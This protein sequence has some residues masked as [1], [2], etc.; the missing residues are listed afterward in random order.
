MDKIR[1]MDDPKARTLVMPSAGTTIIVR[2][3]TLSTCWTEAY[4]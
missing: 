1:H 2:L 3:G 4:A